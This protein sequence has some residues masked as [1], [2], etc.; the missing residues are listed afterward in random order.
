MDWGFT[1]MN[2]YPLRTVPSGG[3][4]K[5]H[6]FCKPST[7]IIL[8][9][10][11]LHSVMPLSGFVSYTAVHKVRKR[12]LMSHHTYVA[13]CQAMYTASQKTKNKGQDHNPINCESLRCV[14]EVQ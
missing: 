13:S 2:C 12:F 3:E 14:G 11:F 6:W 4:K 9:I 10:I 1:E 5:R 8:F 7:S